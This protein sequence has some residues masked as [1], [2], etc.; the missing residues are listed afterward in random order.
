MTKRW[1]VT[2]DGEPEH[3]TRTREDARS[4]A[5]WLRRHPAAR[6]RQAFGRGGDVTIVDRSRTVAL[7]A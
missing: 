4:Y 7:N 5:R 2:L 1:M 6:D 3:Y